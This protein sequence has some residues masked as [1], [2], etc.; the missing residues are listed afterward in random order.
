MPRRAQPFGRVD[1]PCAERLAARVM[2]IHVSTMSEQAE[3]ARSTGLSST[4]HIERR[5][6]EQLRDA[7]QRL[8]TLDRDIQRF[9]RRKP[10]TAAL[11]ALAIG[12]VVGRLAS[13][14]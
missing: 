2:L 6:E 14:L 11:T 4:R 12:F 9:V 1:R 10:L 8:S 5:V 13:R 3:H 7:T